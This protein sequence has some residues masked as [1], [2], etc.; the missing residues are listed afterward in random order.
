MLFQL[1]QITWIHA[2]MGKYL[3]FLKCEM[4]SLRASASKNI[5]KSGWIWHGKNERGLVMIYWWFPSN[6]LSES[7]QESV[8][9][10]MSVEQDMKSKNWK[11]QAKTSIFLSLS[12]KRN[13]TLRDFRT[14]AFISF[15]RHHNHKENSWHYKPVIH[16]LHIHVFLCKTK[17]FSWTGTLWILITWA[18]ALPLVEKV[19]PHNWHWNGFSPVWLRR[20]MSMWLL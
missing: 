18:L 10:K 6:V 2:G 9:N 8:F 17:T 16:A 15:G 7:L 20:W 11:L 13:I 5:R 4:N 12:W 1:C 14:N 3:P 19:L